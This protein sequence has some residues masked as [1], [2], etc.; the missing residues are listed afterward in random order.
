MRQSGNAVPRRLQW[1]FAKNIRPG[2]NVLDT[3]VALSDHPRKQPKVGS[4]CSALQFKVASHHGGEVTVRGDPEVTLHLQEKQRGRSLFRELYPYSVGSQARV[5][6]MSTFSV[7]L[8]PA[9]LDISGSIL[10]DIPMM[11]FPW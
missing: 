4:V 2:K 9:L 11:I 5:I 3:S 8:P 1:E 6:M 10:T 7:G